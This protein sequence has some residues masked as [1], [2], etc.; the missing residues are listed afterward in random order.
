MR[1]ALRPSGGRGD[2]ELAGTYNEIKASDLLEKR[3]FFQITPAI[4]IDG[5]AVARRLSG[6]PRIRPDGGRHAYIL[7]SSILLLPTPRRELLKTPKRFPATPEPDVHSC[8]NRYRRF[9]RGTICSCFRS[10][11]CL[12]GQSRR[13]PQDRLCQQNGRY[14]CVVEHSKLPQ[15]RDCCIGSGP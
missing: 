14:N 2:Y 1:I 8:R 12:G 4:T 9:E 13:P 5:R 10:Q 15:Y 3:F 11:D 6:K 7:I